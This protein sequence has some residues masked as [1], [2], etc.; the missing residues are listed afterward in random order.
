MVGCCFCEA[1]KICYPHL[2]RLS[3]SIRHEFL[4]FIAS[5]SVISLED[6]NTDIGSL[7]HII[8]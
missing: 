5:S 6:R 3:L 7:R 2:Q 1:M 4:S 8:L